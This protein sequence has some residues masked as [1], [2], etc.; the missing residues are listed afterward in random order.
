MLQQ[1]NKK[2]IYVCIAT[3]LLL[4]AVGLA[5]DFGTPP[6]AQNLDIPGILNKILD[7]VWPIFIG[8]AIIMFIVA[9]FLF[10]K[11]QGDPA[12]TKT[13]QKAVMWGVVGII[14]GILAFSIPRIVTSLL[15][16]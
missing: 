7:I 6:V 15:G 11:A 8:L 10:L 4:P 16:F 1:I 12:E 14:V 2:I 5:V 13:A 3:A 9:G